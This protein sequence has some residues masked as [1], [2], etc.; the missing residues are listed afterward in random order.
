MHSETLKHC[1]GW[2]AVSIFTATQIVSHNSHPG[3]VLLP[4]AMACLKCYTACT[5]DVKRKRRICSI[6]ASGNSCVLCAV[7]HIGATNHEAR[8]VGSDQEALVTQHMSLG[9]Y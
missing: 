9:I 6:Y 5:H 2:P 4:K 1:A 8:V 7:L 3:R